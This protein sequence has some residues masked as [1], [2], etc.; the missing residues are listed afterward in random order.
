MQSRCQFS[1]ILVIL[2]LSIASPIDASSAHDSTNGRFQATFLGQP[3]PDKAGQV[4]LKWGGPQPTLVDGWADV[5]GNGLWDPSERIL[6]TVSV[7]PGI[8]V[9]EFVMPAGAAPCERV[10][11][12]FADSG[13]M[14]LAITMTAAPEAAGVCGW[15]EGFHVSDLDSVPEALAVFDDGEGPDLYAAGWFTRANGL[16]VN[17]VARWD[18]SSWTSVG[19]GMASAPP[20]SSVVDCLAVFDSGGGDELYAGGRFDTA[21]GVPAVNI[22][23]WNGTSWSAVGGGLTN[24]S[25][26]IY[27]ESMAVWDDGDG[28][29]LYVGGAFDQAGSATVSNI[30][31][32]DGAAWSA[33]GAGFDNR[34]RAMEAFDDGDG[35]TLY[36]GGYFSSAGGAAAGGIARWDGSAWS[37]VG[38]GFD[39]GVEALT[40]FDDG[41]GANLYAGG[42]FFNAGATAVEKI[43]RWDGAAW[44]GVGGGMGTEFDYG[45]LVNALAVYGGELVA[46][47]RF[48][49]AGGVTVSNTAVWDGS[50]WSA[51]GAGTSGEVRSLVVMDDDGGG[52]GL[53]VSGFFGGSGGLMTGHIS[54]W[55]SDAWSAFTPP[56]GLGVN[57]DDVYTMTVWDDGTGDAL[58]VGGWGL[59]SAGD[60][61]TS[62]IA[63]WDGSSWSS[64]GTG[65]DGQVLTMAVF[66]DGGGEDLYVGGWIWQVGGMPV[67]NIMR[68]DGSAWSTVGDGLDDFVID[69]EVFDDG[70]GPKLYAGGDFKKSGSLPVDYIARWDGSA[71]SAVGGGADATIL[72][73]KAHDDGGGTNLYAG[74][75]FNTAGGVPSNR[76]ASWNGS[77]WSPLGT[78][79]SEVVVALESFDDGGGSQLYVGGRFVTAGGVSASNI[80]RWT[81]S[82]WFP[83]GSGTDDD[84]QTLVVADDGSGA[85]L[86]VGGKFSVAGGSPANLV[87]RWNGATWQALEG[88][89]GN[90]IEGEQALA[91]A[92]FPHDNHAVY[93]GAS[94]AVTAGGVATRGIA[95]WQCSSI[96][97]DGF[98]SG[99]T[100]VW[101]NTVP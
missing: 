70:G 19:G 69:L 77:V 59:Y 95:L 88:P 48:V 80:A 18:G 100:T 75:W 74:G 7:E 87:A 4:A 58:Y 101:S 99:D 83:V 28:S 5:D 78:G 39:D 27:V 51:M 14:D 41:G 89:A 25:G 49:D 23:K 43:A 60:V 42:W 6:D 81:G 11:V 61:D 66:D 40:V 67:E 47:G 17:H 52:L 90:G 31:K 15:Q 21:G 55:R 86:Y 82:A 46:A 54:R 13:G 10:A 2:A 1:A 97:F 29:A 57:A 98:E 63:R 53:I 64:L 93:V 65:V 34:V 62:G 9:V 20:S 56:T 22:A 45:H 37:A 71:W 3:G 38:S 84:I 68:W 85:A 30:A 94:R 92:G 72:A 76:I 8:T 96:Y 16:S 12:R 26:L 79:I 91:I 73:L 32:W 24:T 35:D 44:S 36:A 50:A 33:L